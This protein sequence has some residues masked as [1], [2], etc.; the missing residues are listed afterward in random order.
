MVFR[1]SAQQFRRRAYILEFLLA[2]EAAVASFFNATFLVASGVPEERIGLIYAGAYTL[3]ICALLFAPKLLRKIGNRDLFTQGAAFASLIAFILSFLS[4]AALIVPL[5][6]FLSIILLVIFFALD[7][8]LESTTVNESTG[9]TRAFAL[10]MAN[11]A[12]VIAPLIGAQLLATEDFQRLYLFSATVLAILTYVA[13]NSLTHYE[14]PVYEEVA[15]RS[16]IA[17]VRENKNLRGVFSAQ[18]LLRFYYSMEV[19]FLPV[20]LHNNL[21]ISLSEMGIIFTIMLLP[22]PLI[23]IPLGRLSDWRF[24]EKEILILG[25]TIMS[26]SAIALSFITTNAPSTWAIA[27]IITSIGAAMV[28]IANET[29]FFKQVDG[30]SIGTISGFRMLYPLAYIAGPV[31]GTLALLF[32]PLQFIFAF[33]GIIVSLGILAAL[34]IKDSR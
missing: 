8:F 4:G 9:S 19:V 5:F 31:S 20:Y 6:I 14:D 29:F 27:L 25:F 17:R 30:R 15:W 28:E 13:W 2:L 3:G 16:V 18:F 23:Q 22:F 24:G 7:I 32:I 10:T 21:G 26:I 1:R 12:F 33:F 11:I 34:L